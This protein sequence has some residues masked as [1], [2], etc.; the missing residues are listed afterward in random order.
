MVIQEIISKVESNLKE[1]YSLWEGFSL[2]PL[3]NYEKEAI[4]REAASYYSGE[5][6]SEFA[7]A[8]QSFFLFRKLHEEAGKTS[9][10][11]TLLGDYFFSLFSNHL[12][13]I[14][15][16]ELIDEF[17]EFLSGDT[18]R[19]VKGN[20]SFSLDKYFLFIRNISLMI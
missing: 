7:T 15:N 18:L 12:I 4:P 16:T 8:C 9:E 6:S 13:P 2:P 11:S 1:G 14:D 10:E 20:E 5:Y 19:E 17:A 3:S